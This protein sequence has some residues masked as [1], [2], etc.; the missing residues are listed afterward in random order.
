MKQALLLI[1]RRLF[2]TTFVSFALTPVIGY[3]TASFFNMVE[4][5]SLFSGNSGFIL[6]AI[7]SGLLLY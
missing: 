7:Y 1:Q 4:L 6:I 3:I 2:F 5:K